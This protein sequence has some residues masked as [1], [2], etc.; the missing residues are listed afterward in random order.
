MIKPKR[1]F[2]DL[3][4]AEKAVLS[5]R[6][7]P[8]EPPVEVAIENKIFKQTNLKGLQALKEQCKNERLN[9]FVKFYTQ[10]DGF[11]L[12]KYSDEEPSLLTQLPIA[13]FDFFAKKYAPNAEWSFAI[14]YSKA[15]TLYRSGQAWLPF[16]IVEAG[17]S[18]LTVFFGRRTCRTNISLG[19]YTS[20]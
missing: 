1:N 17:P 20:F 18:C 10:Y 3:F 11:Y 13:E 2:L 9:D 5:T 6:F 12:G 7:Y 19:T 16:A 15:K 14:D 8:D 4:T